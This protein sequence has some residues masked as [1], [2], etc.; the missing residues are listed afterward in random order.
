ML[1]DWAQFRVVLTGIIRQSRGSGAEDEGKA[2]ESATFAFRN[3]VGS[4]LRALQAEV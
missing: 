3:I 4:P 1:G 2:T